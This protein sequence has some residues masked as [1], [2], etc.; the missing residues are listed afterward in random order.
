MRETL[1]EAAAALSDLTSCVL[2]AVGSHERVVSRGLG[3]IRQF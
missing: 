3:V 1:E 2:P